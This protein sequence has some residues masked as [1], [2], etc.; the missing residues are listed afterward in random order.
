MT[1]PATVPSH[2]DGGGAGILVTYSDNDI[3]ILVNATGIARFYANGNIS[4][5]TGSAVTTSSNTGFLNIPSTAGSP[6][7]TPGQTTNCAIDT[8]N[9]YLNCYYGAAWHKIAFAAGAG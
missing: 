8:T 5:G 7:G 6:T 4:L 1:P 9:G 2:S 3:A